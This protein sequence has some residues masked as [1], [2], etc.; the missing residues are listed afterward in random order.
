[1]KV[2]SREVGDAGGEWLVGARGHFIVVTDI[3]TFGGKDGLSGRCLVASFGLGVGVV[4]SSMALI[5]FDLAMLI[6]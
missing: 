6:R 4:V 2:V 1:M 3:A 5:F